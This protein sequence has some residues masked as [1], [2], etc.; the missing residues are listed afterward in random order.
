M[1]VE[2]AGIT[3]IYTKS[4]GS[5]TKQNSAKAVI[6]ALKQLKTVEQLAELRDVSVDHILGK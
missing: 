5:R 3:D 6:K 4:Y 1:V 2:L